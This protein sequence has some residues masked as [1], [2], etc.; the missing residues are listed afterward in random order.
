MVGRVNVGGFNVGGSEIKNISG[1]FTASN[2]SSQTSFT[3]TGVEFTPKVIVVM[4]TG[5]NTYD[6]DGNA[7]GS[8]H[9]LSFQMIDLINNVKFAQEFRSDLA[10]FTYIF[11]TSAGG[12]SYNDNDNV[13][14]VTSGSIGYSEVETSGIRPST[15]GTYKYY[16]YGI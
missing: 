13:L 15:W 7:T 10:D 5:S 8:A 14:T 11:S 1:T 6:H 16:I 2:S 12:A 9:C 3:V 4:M